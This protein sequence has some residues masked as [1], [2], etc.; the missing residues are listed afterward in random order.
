VKRAKKKERKKKHLKIAEHEKPKDQ[1]S[2]NV[3]G[4]KSKVKK[5]LKITDREKHRDREREGG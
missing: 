1:E 2:A 4:Q 5:A 3:K